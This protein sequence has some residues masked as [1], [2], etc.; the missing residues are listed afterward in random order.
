MRF[1][2]S[3]LAESPGGAIRKDKGTRIKEKGFR[4]QD[5]GFRKQ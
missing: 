2:S 3:L 1:E 4:I 5:S